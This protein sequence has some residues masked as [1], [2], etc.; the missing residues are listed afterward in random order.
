[1]QLRVK[2]GL[3]GPAPALL[4]WVDKVLGLLDM[5]VEPRLSTDNRRGCLSSLAFTGAK[6][7]AIGFTGK[8]A[9]CARFAY[10]E[11]RPFTLVNE[12]IDIFALGNQIHSVGAQQ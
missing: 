9:Q 10:G 2:Y 5:A 12:P 6:Q 7:V 1:M 4:T 3:D 8:A 11:K